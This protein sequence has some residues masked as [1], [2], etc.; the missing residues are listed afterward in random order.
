MK[1]TIL[2]SCVFFGILVLRATAQFELH[3]G[4]SQPIKD[5]A[6]TDITKD[7]GYGKGGLVLQ[8]GGPLTSGDRVNL[9]ANMALGYNAMDSRGF[10]K[11]YANA[12]WQADPTKSADS[13]V[14]VKLGTYLYTTLHIG[15]EAK[16]P[17]GNH[18]IPLRVLAGPHM[19]FPPNKST[20][21]R[22]AGEPDAGGMEVTT[23]YPAIWSYEVI[24]LSYQLGTGVVLSDQLSV[25]VEYFGTLGQIG[26]F[27]N[28]PV[29]ARMLPR[30]FHSLFF[31]V[32]ILF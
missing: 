18:Y 22:Y 14:S 16:V 20:I 19:F 15:L 11:A 1:K 29:P 6:A 2:L 7:S 25:R 26:Q 24:G 30:Q 32:G 28:P 8:F 13:L 9:V 21:R 5:W 12:Y 17:L 10:G 23:E 3:V 31:S 4:Y 27:T